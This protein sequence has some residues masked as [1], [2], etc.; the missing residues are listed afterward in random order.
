[1]TPSLGVI[2]TSGLHGLIVLR[3]RGLKCQRVGA[4][5]VGVTQQILLDAVEI[6]GGAGDIRGGRWGR[7]GC[8]CRCGGG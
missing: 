6:V 8:Y 2:E 5:L 1:M 7:R 3:G 4:H